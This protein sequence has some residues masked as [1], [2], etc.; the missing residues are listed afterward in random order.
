MNRTTVYI[1]LF[2]LS[3]A[4]QNNEP[5]NPGK[6]YGHDIIY[7]ESRKEIV[8]FGGFRSDAT[9]SD[10]TWT[11][12]VNGEKLTQLDQKQENGPL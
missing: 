8:L 9:L 1:V 5:K 2:F 4:C 7:D 6:V 12:S 3:I 11:W 10:E